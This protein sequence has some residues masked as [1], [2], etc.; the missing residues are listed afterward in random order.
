MDTT[1]LSDENIRFFYQTVQ[2][3]DRKKSKKTE[4]KKYPHLPLLTNG[5][6]FYFFTQYAEKYLQEWEISSSYF[7]SA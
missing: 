1:F 5:D 7:K 6:I 4:S 3:P 2:Q